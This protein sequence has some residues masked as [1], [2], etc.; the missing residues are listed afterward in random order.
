V[1]ERPDLP[2]LN[3]TEGPNPKLVELSELLMGTWRVEGPEIN[4][5]AVYQAMKDGRLLVAYVDFSVGDSRMRV[6]QHIT[7]NQDRGALLAR[8]MDTMGDEAT[9][10]WGLEGQDLRVS[11]DGESDTYFHA[12]VTEERTQYVGTW[13][14]ADGESPDTSESIVYTK[15]SDSA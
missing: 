7:F 12:I 15:V 5:Q 9:Y 13:H 8:Y 4:G 14:H 11:L 1:A 10:V 2:T 6:L 3:P